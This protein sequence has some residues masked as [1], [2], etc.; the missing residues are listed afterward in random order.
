MNF[1][2]LPHK[3]GAPN[4]QHLDKCE[5]QNCVFSCDKSEASTA[6]ALL[7]HLTDVH[8]ELVNNR[9]AKNKLYSMLMFYIL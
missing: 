5:Y 4:F 1:P 9:L 8:G 6:D 7:F 2:G 3:E